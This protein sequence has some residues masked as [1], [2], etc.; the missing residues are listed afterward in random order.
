MTPDGPA[1]GAFAAAATTA[2]ANAYYTRL[3]GLPD[4]L[5]Q[6]AQNAFTISGFLAAGLVGASALGTLAGVTA[7]ARAAGVAGLV[8]WAVAAVL[9]ARAVAGAVEP[10]TAGAQPGAQALAA[11]ILRNVEA[12]YLAVERR[13]R[14]GQ[15]AAAL[16]AAATV[17]AVALGLLLPRPAAA[18]RS[19]VHLTPEG[20]RAVAAACGTGAA[21]F[22]ADVVDDPAPRGYLRVRPAAGP[23][24]GR[25]LTIPLG[26]VAVVVT[27]P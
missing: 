14:A 13:R 1:P 6:R 10:V 21:P 24:A 8:L 16:A 26:A 18:T 15:L 12:E 20:G 19:L 17:T 5:R 3:V 4:Q 22:A 9:F 11:A 25:T 7:A 2:L 27:A 23:C